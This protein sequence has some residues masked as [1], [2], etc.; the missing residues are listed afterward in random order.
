MFIVVQTTARSY[1]K[2][3]IRLVGKKSEKKEMR[4]GDG[5]V[6]APIKNAWN[7]WKRRNQDGVLER[8]QNT[9]NTLCENSGLLS[10]VCVRV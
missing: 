5:T 4:R 10:A 8:G 6:S 7:N 1:N 2:S 9:S 3:K